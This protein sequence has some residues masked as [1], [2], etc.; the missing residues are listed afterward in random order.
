[1]PAG[2]AG[3]AGTMTLEVDTKAPTVDVFLDSFRRETRS[4]DVQ[5]QRSG[6]PGELH[7]G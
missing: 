3:L 7:G 1:M 4:V 5:L 6:E 2:N